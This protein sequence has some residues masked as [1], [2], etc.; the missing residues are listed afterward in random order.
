MRLSWGGY[1]L[2]I[3][4]SASVQATNL[5]YIVAAEEERERR[6]GCSE[7]VSDGNPPCENAHSVSG[8]AA[9]PLPAF[10]EQPR[11][12]AHPPAPN[13]IP[14][15][16]SLGTTADEPS[17]LPPSSIPAA[18]P[19]LST[20]AVVEPVRNPSAEADITGDGPQPTPSSPVEDELQDPPTPLT[21]PEQPTPGSLVEDEPQDSPT[22]F[23][24][25]EQPTPGSLVEDEPQDSP[26]PPITPEQPTPGSL[27]ED[28]PQDPPTPL[29]T[30]E[31]PNLH[32]PPSLATTAPPTNDPTLVIDSLG[33]PAD[34]P[35]RL[36]AFT[37]DPPPAF[38]TS[39]TIKYLEAVPGDEPWINMVNAY[40]KFEEL[41]NEKDV[42]I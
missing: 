34:A 8:E 19:Q 17:H 4:S 1:E 23:T 7:D 2:H 5:S 40:F 24:T 41:S 12:S 3:V 22:P 13:G 35:V 15:L 30:P 38:I 31:Q 10:D 37:I 28:E 11:V 18:A 20:D 32:D 42:R 36:A 33:C 6:R 26:T 16:L 39:D 25:P 21:T 9:P 27:V 14:E 29:T